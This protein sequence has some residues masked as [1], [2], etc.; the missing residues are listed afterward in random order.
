MNRT[1]FERFH[2]C[3]LH[4]PGSTAE[5]FLVEGE[6]AASAVARV[7]DPRTQAVLALRGKPLN[8]WKATAAAVFRH[9]TYRLLI[10][11]LGV[12]NPPGI[13]LENRRFDRVIL[14]CD[15]DAD[16][17]HCT[18]LLLLFFFRWMR[19]LIDSGVVGVVLAPQF[20]VRHLETDQR[21]Y[22]SDEQ[23]PR[24]IQARAADQYRVTRIRGL[25]SISGEGLA[26]HCVVQETRR[27]FRLT[28]ADAEAA[29][30]SLGG[31]AF[32]Q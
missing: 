26:A 30:K 9:D 11:A 22:A 17:V 3:E 28:A 19:L 20:E 16:G 32:R 6:S 5:L 8:A 12:G 21:F 13:S 10:E 7:R 4:G 23:E 18:A 27:Y 2:D 24:L 31:G 25:A 14:L 29:A 1:S 15:P